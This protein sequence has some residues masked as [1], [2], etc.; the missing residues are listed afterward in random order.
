MVRIREAKM[1]EER[2]LN[3]FLRMVSD[4]FEKQFCGNPNP[5]GEAYHRYVLDTYSD[6]LVARWE[7]KKYFSIPFTVTNGEV[8]FAAA[9]QWTQVERAYVAV[10]EAVRLLASRKA[11]E[12]EPEGREWEVV[13]IGPDGA[14]D[15][16]SEGGKTY[17]RSKNGRLYDA[18]AL[19]ASVPLWD[20]VK[21]YDNHL[22]D[23]EMLAK[24]G[25][26]SVVN[27]WVGVIVQPA[28]DATRKAVTGVLKLV[29]DALRV[30]LVNAEKAGV[31]GT[32]GLS[33]DALG[34]SREA[35]VA[36]DKAPVITKISK[37]LSVDVVA[38]PAAGGRLA[39]MLA[40]SG[41]L[42]DFNRQMEVEMDPEELK[43]LLETLLAASVA[44]LEDRLKVIETRIAEM[45]AQVDGGQPS[46]E[47]GIPEEVQKALDEARRLVAEAEQKAKLSECTALLSAKLQG[48]GLP[49]S[50]REL[51]AKQFRGQV[52]EEAALDAAIKDHREAL[53]KI[54]ESGQVVLPAGAARIS[55][56]AL[57][58]LDRY[59]L[60]FMRL[61][62]GATRFNEM[63]TKENA[64]K[65]ELGALSRFVEAGKPALP[66]ILRL[67]EWYYQFTEDYDAVGVM[68]NPRL[69]EANV[70]STALASIVKNT[71]NILMANDYSQRDQWWAPVVRQEDVDTLDQATLVRVYGISN[72]ATIAEGDAYVETSW[73]DEEETATWVKRGNYLG[74]SLETFLLDKINVLRSL[75]TRLANAWYNTVSALVA[76]VFTVN[77][78]SG[79]VLADTG[80]LFNATALTS[81]GGHANL[82][83]TALSYASFIAARTAMMKQTDQPLGVGRRLGIRPRYLMVP[84]DLIATAEQIRDSELVP[85]QIGGGET[86]SPGSEYQT[87]NAV[88]GQFD[89][90]HVPDWTDVNNWAAVGDPAQF[91]AIWLIWLRGRRTPELFSA[92]DEQ[93]GA[94]FTNDELRFKVRQYGFRFSSTYDC[95]P[96]SD[97]RALYKANVV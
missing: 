30:K 83:T 56:S 35:R 94:M 7:D 89:I 76:G 75:P 21:V 95:A 84:A 26:R 78:A 97:F 57:S 16:V 63:A 70:T 46:S 43:K 27:E 19:E 24:Q 90:V 36:G 18:A 82:G 66:R 64:A 47:E 12:G 68:R 53:Q 77:S 13:I 62:A 72:L 29:D 8:M 10:S 59:E 93:N 88:R 39:R 23:A 96:V 81:A 40:G 33:I 79:P 61:V 91:P 38:D 42:Q 51:V 1:A 2:S 58:E 31:L 11:A 28:W 3:D 9:D 25:M 69:R 80:A 60:A 15:L 71:V 85:S 4:E 65:H 74:V 67:S 52:F 41:P 49:E 5:N 86:T 45:A 73:S 48:S 50:Y 14:G 6:H 20:G 55:V 37:A 22:T 92:E 17:I 87:K 34:E 32:I 54:S 44:G